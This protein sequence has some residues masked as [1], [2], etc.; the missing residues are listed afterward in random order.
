MKQVLRILVSEGFR[1]FFLAGAGF[2]LF[3]ICI[4]TVLYG[5]ALVGWGF[6]LPVAAPSHQWHG[7]E[8]VFGYGGAALGGFFLT[9][10]PNWTGAKSAP[11]RF[12]A[13]VAGLWLAGRLAV[14]LSGVVP[15]EFVALIDLSFAPILGAKILSQLLKKPRPQNMIFLLFLTYFWGSNLLVHLEWSGVLADVAGSG[16]RGGL[17]A[18]VGMILILGGR[19][20][21]AFT[22]NAMHRAGIDRGLPYEPKVFTPLTIALA[23]L[24]PPVAMLGQGESGA[25]G[26]LYCGAGALA[27][28]RLAF[29]HSRFQWRQP[30]LWS[31]HVSYAS[32][33]LGLILT[34]SAV[35]TP[36][37]ELAALHFL[38]IAGIGGMTVAVMSRASLG[39][40]GRP[41][42]AARPV[43]LAF[44]LLPLAG[45]VRFVG[46]QVGGSV[47]VSSIWLAGGL[48]C[49]AFGGFLAVYAPILTSP[50]PP[51]APAGPPPKS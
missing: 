11:H 9:A 19:I 47:Y 33:G 31:L 20:T 12:I 27:L 46:G 29:W 1:V 8:M 42:V 21:P 25:G 50:R 41:L 51:R 26:F 37:V 40:A 39:H 17:L 43:V 6:G 7:H 16:L 4:W 23:A 35:I 38:S 45:L 34:G 44:V 2:G 10:V 14:W 49:L 30:I 5:A 22:R 15:A 18:L 28:M 3:A 32:A 48:W 24:L 13:L 36:V